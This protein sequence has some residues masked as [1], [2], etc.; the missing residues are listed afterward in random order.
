MMKRKVR[1]FQ[2]PFETAEA[3]SIELVRR[4]KETK[5]QGRNLTIALSGG[6]T[7]LLLFSILADHFA[8][9]VK[10]DS[11]HFFWADERM[12]GPDH[13]E[14]N[15]GMAFRAFLM[16]VELPAEN[17]HRIMGEND[18]DQEV[19]RYSTEVEKYTKKENELPVFD[20]ILLGLGNDGHTASIFPGNER[21]FRTR[22]ICAR[23]V[24]PVSGQERITLTGGILNNACE[25]FFL[26]SGRDKA[27][28][29]KAILEE[30]SLRE[31]FPASLVNPASGKLFWFLDMEAAS[32]CSLKNAGE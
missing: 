26:I 7:P 17:I 24:H 25:V 30:N 20:I 32:E 15:F 5:K 27:H 21:L 12:V 18:I 8:G 11:T 13:P 2:T 23:A 10:W 22:K 6:K 9:E 19:A 14:S 4:V 28:V 1:I 3:L 16:K 31:L 29:V